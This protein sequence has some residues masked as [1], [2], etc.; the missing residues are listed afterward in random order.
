MLHKVKTTAIY[1]Y[2]NNKNKP[3]LQEKKINSVLMMSCSPPNVLAEEG[4]GP[5]TTEITEAKPFYY[6][7][8]Y[9]Q[10]YL[11]KNPHGYCGLGGT[12]VTCP[13]G[14]S[15][16]HVLVQASSVITVNLQ[17]C[18]FLNTT[19][20]RVCVW[21]QTHTH[22]SRRRK[23]W[24]PGPLKPGTDIT[25]QTKED[26]SLWRWQSATLDLCWL[27]LQLHWLLEADLEHYFWNK[28]AVSLVFFFTLSDDKLFLSQPDHVLNELTNNLIIKCREVVE[29]EFIPGLNAGLCC[30]LA[31]FLIAVLTLPPFCQTPGFNLWI[32]ESLLQYVMV[33]EETWWEESGDV[34]YLKARVAE[35]VNQWVQQAVG[36]G[37]NHEGVVHLDHHVLQLLTVFQPHDQ[38]RQPSHRAWQ[39]ADG[40]D[41]GD[42]QDGEH[43]S[44][45]FGL[46]PNR[47]PPQ[48]TDD[49]SCAVNEDDEGEDDLREEDDLKKKS[50]LLRIAVLYVMD[51]AEVAVQGQSD[52]EA[53]AGPSIEEQHEVHQTANNLI[54]TVP[55]IVLIVVN[56][57]RNTDHQQKISNH[58]VEEEHA[59][60]IPEDEDVEHRQV[61][62]KS[63]NELHSHHAGEDLIPGKQRQQTN[64]RDQKQR[65]EEEKTL[66]LSVCVLTSGKAAT[67]S[68]KRKKVYF[69]WSFKMC[70]KH[71]AGIQQVKKRQPVPVLTPLP[72]PLPSEL[73]VTLRCFTLDISFLQA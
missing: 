6:A 43:G 63:Q 35:A 10:Q 34:S 54:L 37:P 53:D 29:F 30:H 17:A 46:F 18:V 15:K 69:I 25:Q 41:D 61:E 24:A 40:E 26:E 12:G 13:I 52:E 9:H 31:C 16:N 70:E 58:N 51:D 8:D 33:A 1:V 47:F 50:L 49:A 60:K 19:C 38:Q 57:N 73:N 48:S 23:Y 4:F 64:K 56:F 42:R 20:T 3:H 71:N 5:I 62:R 32:I 28:V 2:N 14:L 72:V 22:P 65:R 27:G 66:R 55:Q 21:M 36:V 11:S 7:E 44:P 68:S 39:E 59:L 67:D 45:Q